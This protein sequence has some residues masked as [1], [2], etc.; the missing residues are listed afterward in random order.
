MVLIVSSM[1]SKIFL[2]ALIISVMPTLAGAE[3]VVW[4]AVQPDLIDVGSD[5]ENRSTTY[6]YDSSVSITYNVGVSMID[7]QGNKVRPIA[8]GESLPENTRVLLEFMPHVYTDIYW[9]GTGGS[10]DSP[11]GDWTAAAGAPPGAERC[12][13]K[14]LYQSK[15]PLSKTSGVDLFAALSVAP[16][17][18]NITMGGVTASCVA[19]GSAGNQ[20]C[21][22]TTPGTVNATFRFQPTKGEFYAGR[23]EYQYSVNP[24]EYDDSPMELYRGSRSSSGDYELKVPLREVPFTINVVQRPVDQT[25][26]T[27]PAASNALQCTVGQPYAITMTATDP[28]NDR[29]RYGIDW[30]N[31]GTVDEYVPSSGYVNSGTSQTASR[32]Y[33]TAG[34]KTVR[35]LAQDEG[36]LSSGWATITF[37]CSTPT[38]IEDDNNN[39]QPPP[40]NCPVGYTLQNNT[41][42]FTGCPSGFT[43]QGAAC[44]MV[45]TQ[46]TA[47]NF[48]IGDNLYHRNAQCTQAFVQQCV[49]GC[50]GNVCRSAA[51]GSGDII[52]QPM[53]VQ[54]GGTTNVTWQTNGMEDDSCIV[55]DDNPGI[56]TNRRGESGSFVSGALHQVTTFTLTCD[57]ELGGRFTD[58]VTVN[59]V[60]IFEEN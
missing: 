42:V 24:C 46:C 19:S 38:P 2:F 47:T 48:C 43:Q 40:A 10:Y 28:Q 25:P 32:T 53:L 6:L 60:P 14:N 52:A 23:I 35:V 1:R 36:G 27:T 4:S 49:F 58:S 59:I 34:S 41:C 39:N 57:R 31:N 22:L 17:V 54:A 9:F 13:Q 37:T 26:P 45:M 51:S 29:I 12:S 55:T 8:N 56:T 50:S 16:P 18:K 7:E 30:D 33:A 21:T 11:Y 20:I 3:S 5:G 44:V 15:V